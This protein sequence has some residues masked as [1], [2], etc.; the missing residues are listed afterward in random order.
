MSEIENLIKHLQIVTT[1]VYET[2]AEGIFLKTELSALANQFYEEFQKLDIHLHNV[3]SAAGVYRGALENIRNT[4]RKE[5][6]DSG[7]LTEAHRQI[8]IRDLL[9]SIAHETSRVLRSE[10]VGADQRRAMR[11]VENQ[12]DLYEQQVQQDGGWRYG[13]DQSLADRLVRIVNHYTRMAA[14]AVETQQNERAGVVSWLRGIAIN[15]QSV[16]W[17]STHHEKDARLRGLIEVIDTAIT[18]IQEQNSDSGRYFDGG[19]DSWMRSDFPTRDLKRTILDQQAE[20]KRLKDL[21]GEVP[22]EPSAPPPKRSAILE[23]IDQ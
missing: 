5:N 11:L 22:P 8:F 20:I 14:F 4:A 3:V 6:D 1:K 17:A 21:V 19:I 7:D 2:D 18:K 23:T 10:T 16:S 13:Y 12:I 9:G 15:A